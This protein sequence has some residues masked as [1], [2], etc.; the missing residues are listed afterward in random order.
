MAIHDQPRD[1]IRF[2][3]NHGVVQKMRQR[4][5]GQRALSRDPLGRALGRDAGQCVARAGRR[6]ARQQR[7][8][9]R[10]PVLCAADTLNETHAHPLAP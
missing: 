3:G 10:E 1:F 2:I 9:I 4:Q 5:V 8:Q 6:G 7:P